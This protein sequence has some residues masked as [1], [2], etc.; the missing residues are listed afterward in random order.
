[1]N[2]SQQDSS[3]SRTDILISIFIGITTLALYIRTVAPSLLWGDSAEFQ[4]LSYTLGMSH[5]SGYMTQIMIGKLFTYLPVGNI[6]YRVNLVSAFFGALAVAQLYLLVRLL[7]SPRLAALSASIMLAL[8]PMFWWR[9]LVAESYTPAAAMIA[10]IWLCILLWRRT[11]KWIYLFFA[12]LAGGLSVGLHSTVVMTAASV[13]VTMAITAKRKRVDWLAAATGSLIGVLITL[14]FFF[15]LDYNDPPSSIYNT[16]YR[17]NLSSLSLSKEEFDTPVERFF[18]IFPARHFWSYYFT[19]ER[20]EISRRFNEYLSFYPTWELVLIL[21]GVFMLFRYNWLDALYPVIGFFLIWG[22]AVTVAFS[23]YQEFYTPAAIFVHVWFGIGAGALT[24][25]IGRVFT[26]NTTAL[27]AA[28]GLT[29]ITLVILPIWQSR[30]ELQLAINNGYT[31]FI[32]QAHLYP[33]FAKDEAIHDAAKVINRLEPDAI[34]FTDWDKLYS[35]VY[36]AHIEQGKTGI[37][38]H[39]A[40]VGEDME[41]SASAIEY[42]NANIDKRPIYFTVDIPGLETL[43]QVERINDTLQRIYRK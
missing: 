2:I 6:A 41:L 29:A 8:A 33:I 9:A 5:P 14:A 25:L 1:M 18:A 4:T 7:N 26:R 16:V 23:V 30:S 39:E 28:Q 35:Y 43:Y 22:F 27:R 21:F 31:T 34:V 19:A 12:G 32:R 42:I 15:Y 17:P 13:L 20:G 11:E 10:A 40:W 36:T 37:A 38:F 3:L 24:N